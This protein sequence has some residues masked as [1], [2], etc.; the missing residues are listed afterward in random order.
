MVLEALRI[1][2]P[3]VVL[4]V[5]IILKI[6]RRLGLRLISVETRLLAA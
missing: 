4:V 1:V 5:L 2:V 3:V 6:V